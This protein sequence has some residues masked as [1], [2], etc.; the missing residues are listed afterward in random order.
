MRALP[1][2]RPRL[3]AS[4]PTPKRRTRPRST[5]RRTHAVDRRRMPQLVRRRAL[6]A[7]HPA[8]AGHG[9]GVP[10]RAWSPLDP[11]PSPAN[12]PALRKEHHDHAPALRLQGIRRAVRPP[13]AARLR[14]A[15]RGDGVRLGLRL[16]SPPAVDA[17]GR[18]RPRIAPLAR[19]PRR[20]HVAHRHGHI[21]AHPDLPLP[22]GGHGAGV[23][24]ARRAVPRAASSSASAPARR[25]TK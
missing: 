19:R 2:R 17:R 6:G 24:D 5:A 18:P 21:G 11:R 12:P 23:R 1:R 8:L 4:R 22:P 16:G 10:S 15:R 3:D 20:A 14:R 25:S 7:P 9:R 13:R